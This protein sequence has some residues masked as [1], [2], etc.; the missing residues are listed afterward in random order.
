M[1]ANMC[2]L[3]C[4]SPVDCASI[5]VCVWPVWLTSHQVLHVCGLGNIPQGCGTR[6]DA[7]GSAP[8]LC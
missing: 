1:H 7:Q 3:C 8:M 6:L 5:A 4:D 2:A